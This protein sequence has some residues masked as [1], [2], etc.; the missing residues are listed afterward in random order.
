MKA[1]VGV[2]WDDP[3]KRYGTALTATFVKGK[4]AS[5]TNRE[6]YTNTGSAITDSSSEYMRVPGYGMLDLT[7]W[8]QVAKTCVLTAAFT[9][10]PIDNTGII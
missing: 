3:A 2:A 10:L 4:Q 8:W 6:S 5:A 1:I 7:A 9:T